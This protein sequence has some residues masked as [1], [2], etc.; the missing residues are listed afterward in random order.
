MIGSEVE[1]GVVDFVC[2][3][4]SFVLKNSGFR[5]LVVCCLVEAGTVFYVL[6][7]CCVLACVLD[8]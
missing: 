6:G 3:D 1:R 2:G 7:V 5:V 8:S 4:S